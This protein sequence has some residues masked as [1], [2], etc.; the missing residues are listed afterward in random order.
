MASSVELEPAPMLVVRQGR[1][2]PG[3]SHGHDAVDPAGD[4]ALDQGDKGFL[5]HGPVAERSD[6]G[7][8]HAL[9]Q[10]I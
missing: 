7:R 5:V 6:E 8:H 10:G 9:E 1:G 3:G 4:L 2:L